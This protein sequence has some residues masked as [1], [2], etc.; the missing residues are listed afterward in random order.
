MTS[1]TLPD[2]LVPVNEHQ[3]ASHPASCDSYIRHGWRLVPIPPNTKG[4]TTKG[5]NR[6]ENAITDPAQLSHGHGF[7][8]AHAYSGTMALDVDQWDRAKQELSAHGI[9]LDQ[10]YDAPDAVTIESGNP[11]HGKL[12]Y[13]M[14]PGL[15]LPSKKL[16]DTDPNGLKFNYLDLR[17][18]TSNGLT[19]QDVLPPSR[20]LESDRCYQWGGRGHWTRLPEIPGPLLAF[21]RRLIEQEQRPASTAAGSDHADWQTIRDAL[22][23][24]SPDVDRAEWVSV[25]MAL[26]WAGVC[27]GDAETAF[28]LWDEWSAK[29]ESK[30]R[31]QRD[32]LTQWRSFKADNGITLGTLF[33]FA[34]D[35]GWSRPA[36]DPA[37]LFAGVTLPQLSTSAL[38]ANLDQFALN[39]QSAEMEARMLEDVFVLGRI[40]ILGQSTV[41]F[42]K[43]NSG[44]TLLSLW[45]LIEAINDQRM[46]G[47]NVF[48]VNADDSHKGLAHKLRLAE[49]HGFKML[50]PGYA[51][52]KA[53][54]L[55]DV[56]NQMI[57][58]GE[59]RGRVLILDTLKKFTDLMK[60][61]RASEF[62]EVIRQFVLHGGT[63]VMLA[64]VNKHRAEDGKV[65]YSGTSD[66]VDDADC[67]YTL[68]IVTDDTA[69]GIRT[70]KF[71]NF[72]ARGAVDLEAVY[73]YDASSEASYLDRLDSIKQLSDREKTRAER[74]KKYETDLDGIDAIRIAISEGTVLKTELVKTA[75]TRSALSRRTIVRIL[76]EY[77]GADINNFEFWNLSV[78]AANKNAHIYKLNSTI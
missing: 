47:S 65:I 32:L 10:L 1:K 43:P 9:D 7:G 18:G 38:P 8:L 42:A 27:S 75:T 71:E 74:F 41:I 11:G 37:T 63:A 17:C 34:K 52:F 39:G 35:A 68:D 76:N 24:I 25:G 44:K 28:N 59:S 33:K 54:I 40:A 64:H 51:G 6:P 31:G 23:H 19:C 2:W 29:S 66:S 58:S 69:T 5:W 53:S 26:H 62:G 55:V 30:Y 36:P 48:Y 78:D 45:L 50:A 4:P 13:R 61:D 49:K 22:E 15:V 67:A 12:L 20:Y 60:K 77:T 56:L 3:I 72:K 16:I 73:Q 46:K 21:W 57:A 70:V 14:P